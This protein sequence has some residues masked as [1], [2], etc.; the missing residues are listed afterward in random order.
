MR[1][2]PVLLV[3]ALAF[4]V[5]CGSSTISST[6]GASP[7]VVAPAPA[8]PPS[9]WAGSW[10]VSM[11]N[12]STNAEGNM[13]GQEQT[14]RFLVHPTLGGTQARVRFSNV[15]GTTPVAIGA[16]RLSVGQEGTPAVD[17]L[18]DAALQF[19]GQSGT[20]VA[21]G[22][23]VVSDPVQITF[24][25]GQ[26][27][28]ISMYLKG[29]FGPVSRHS[30][31]F[32]T[33]YRTPAGSGDATADADGTKYTETLTDWLLINGV[34]VYGPYK[35]TLVLFGSSTTD[36]FH[37]DYSSDQ[38][39]PTP[40]VPVPTQHADRLSDQ[41]AARLQ[42]AG[43]KIGVLNAGVPGDT[44]TPDITNQTGNVL[45]ANDRIAQDVLSLPSVLGVVTYFGSIDLRSA[46]CKSA[47][48]METS[49]QQMIA[50]AAAAKIPVVLATLPPSAFCIN[51][52]EA[53]YGPYPSAA[54][55]Y[56]GGATPGPENGAEVQRAAFDAWV[57][58][59][60]SQLSGVVGI[61]DFDK[62]LADP[63]R[64]NFMLP[65]Y[66]SGDNYHPN[67]AGYGAEAAAVPL[68]FL[69]TP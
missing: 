39:Y 30:S 28:A 36:G 5:G 65:L 46:D 63:A 29:S 7:P 18:H 9:L 68:S 3:A 20:V 49:T 53:N 1:L 27:L 48:A 64:P 54:D 47:P 41:V 42:A 61:A 38:V 25:Y 31:I 44:V 6:N 32:V 10:G 58:S 26:V 2:S 67:G 14:F 33:N 13:G 57:R 17:P 15:Y 55:P 52:A 56:A 60:G 59:T 21:P 51:P 40:N 11:T 4:L 66:N 45:N 24:S 62:A 37:S 43:Y 8:V 19:G 16:A 34:D 35:G 50:T 69:G 22:Q 23:V 12:A